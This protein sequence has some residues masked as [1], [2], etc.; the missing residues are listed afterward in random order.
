MNIPFSLLC[1][2]KPCLSHDPFCGWGFLLSW[3][4]GFLNVSFQGQCDFLS[5][6]LPLLKCILMLSLPYVIQLL[7][8]LGSQSGVICVFCSFFGDF[9]NHPFKI[10]VKNLVYVSLPGSHYCGIGLG[11]GLALVFHGTCVSA[12]EFTCLVLGRWLTVFFLSSLSSFGEK[13]CN[14]LEELGCIVDWGIVLLHF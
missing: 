4:P 14:A 12:S 5:E 13:V 8:F 7:G 2:L 3:C 9:N 10:F 1:L 11:K 6:F